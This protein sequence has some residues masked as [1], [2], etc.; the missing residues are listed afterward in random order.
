MY[1]QE[2]FSWAE[3]KNG[4]MVYVDDVPGGASCGC[5][6]PSC[7]EKL[8]ARHG[9]ERAHGFAHASKE[10]GANLNICLK[11]IIFK[12]AEQIIATEKQI[13]L[14]SY[15]GI[16]KSKNITFEKVEINDCFEREDRQ[17][18]IIAI[19]EDGQKYLIE[20]SFKDYVRHK[21]KINYED[22][23][24]L[25]ID[26]SGQRINDRDSLKNFLLCSSYGR[27]WLNNDTYFNS[28]PE[29]Y[30]NAGKAIRLVKSE[31]CIQCK[32]RYSCCAVR[33]NN[34]RDFLQIE[35]NDKKYFLCKL[36]EYKQKTAD[37]DRQQEEFRRI[38]EENLKRYRERIESRKRMNK[39][40]RNM[41][42]PQ[43][44]ETKQVFQNSTPQNEKTIDL[45]AL[46]CFNCTRG[47]AWGKNGEWAHCVCYE[48]LGIP[49]KIDP[50]HAKICH[51]F[52]SKY[53]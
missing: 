46:S 23:N 21:Q 24:C 38:R 50:S 53:N 8:V 16:F 40:D 51:Y 3:D 47:V 11:V 17:P 32:L 31:E 36:D 20:F 52:K 49:K 27:R 42:P 2:V 29:L 43:K 15:Y 48:S 5:V 45:D 14:P 34:Q 9:N 35:Q 33:Y 41:L 13:C 26:L 7:R 22:L 39:E 28:I 6:C 30:K 19:T 44:I 1:Y 37:H 25:E 10:R 18:D 4:K 12:L